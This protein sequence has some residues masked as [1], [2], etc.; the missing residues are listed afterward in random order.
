MRVPSSAYTVLLTLVDDKKEYVTLQDQEH[1]MTGLGEAIR[2]SLRSGDVYTQYSS[3]QFLL[4]VMGT[5]LENAW[6]VVERIRNNYSGGGEG[7]FRVYR[8]QYPS[9]S[10]GG[11]GHDSN[12]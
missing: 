5:S 7:A 4:M 1:L 11:Q 9:A 12:W 2:R 6:K 8:F 10:V 3:C